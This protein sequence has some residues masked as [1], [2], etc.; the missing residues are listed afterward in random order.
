M[1]SA[2]RLTKTPWTLNS[3]VAGSYLRRELRLARATTKNLDNALDR[4]I[5]S[6]RGYDRSLR[7][8]WSIADFHGKASPT[9]EDVAWAAYLRGT[10]L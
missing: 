7:L 2:E 10:E 6:M 9:A 3:E 8:A 5:I 1:A 4:Q